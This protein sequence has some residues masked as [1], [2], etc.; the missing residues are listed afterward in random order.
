MPYIYS[1]SLL[2]KTNIINK[3]CIRDWRKKKELIPQRNN[4]LG[5]LFMAGKQNILK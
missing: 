3:S 4:N 2:M 1:L 5:T